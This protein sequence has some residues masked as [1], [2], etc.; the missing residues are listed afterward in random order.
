MGILLPLYD[1]SF[2]GSAF[3]ELAPSGYYPGQSITT[4]GTSYSRA[5][6]GHTY[7]DM[8]EERGPFEIQA[9]V[10]AA[11]LASLTAKRGDEGT[12]VWS[13]GSQTA[14]LLDIVPRRA[15]AHALYM[16][17]LKFFSAELPAGIVPSS[18]R[19]TESGDVRVTESGDVRI[20]E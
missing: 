13:R 6:A 4:A 14:T 16:V 11:A 7:I 18:A 19:L 8:G 5:G 3:F 1:S 12:L 10:E 20:V 17:S 15:G 9:G 2:D